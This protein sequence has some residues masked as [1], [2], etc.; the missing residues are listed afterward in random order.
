[1]IGSTYSNIHIKYEPSKKCGKECSLPE[2]V[3]STCGRVVCAECSIIIYVA[4]SFLCDGG[5][6][7]SK[8]SELK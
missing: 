8:C 5:I 4:N 3:C 2:E 1:M 6:K 7:C